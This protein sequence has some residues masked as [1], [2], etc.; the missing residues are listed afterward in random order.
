MGRQ[1]SRS[2][3]RVRTRCR[4]RAEAA[5]PVAA[6]AEQRH[7]G[8]KCLEAATALGVRVDR[9]EASGIRRVPRRPASRQAPGAHRTGPVLL[10]GRAQISVN[11]CR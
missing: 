8:L 6:R 4:S 5:A 3:A 10:T 11:F 9:R 2:L 1:Q 7:H